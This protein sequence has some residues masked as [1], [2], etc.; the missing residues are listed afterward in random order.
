V[1]AIVE[2]TRRGQYRFSALVLGVVH[3]V[4]FQYRRGEPGGLAHAG[5]P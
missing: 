1:D 5:A 3:S 2:A 4:P